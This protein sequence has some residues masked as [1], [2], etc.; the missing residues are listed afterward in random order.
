MGA[1]E[2]TDL[3]AASIYGDV[4]DSQS[5][6]VMR[7][8]QTD[9]A[10][11][12][13]RIVVEMAEKVLE[14][15]PGDLRAMTIRYYAANMLGTVAEQRHDLARAEASYMKSA[16][17]AK[18]YTLFNP[19]DSAGWNSLT[20]SGR[21]LARINLEQG[22]LADAKRM[23]RETVAV[24]HDPRN[25]TGMD[26]GVYW[27]WRTLESVQA[28]EDDLPAA[29]AALGEI[30]RVEAVLAKD[31]NFDPALIQIA[32]LAMRLMEFDLLAAQHDYA[33]LHARAVEVRDELAKLVVNDVRNQEFRDDLT[34]ANRTWIIESGLRLGSHE[35]AVTVARDAVEHP[36]PGRLDQPDVD[37]NQ[38]RTRV[39]LGQA[40][41]DNGQRAEG[42][43][44]LETALKYFRA[45][46]AKGA[47][48]TS[49]RQNYARAL[50]QLARAPGSDEAGQARRR[51][52]LDAAAGVLG[53]LT[54]EAQTL[55]TS[56]ELLQ[57]V[58]AA[59]AQAGP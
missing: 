19:A 12:L 24:E 1:L 32:G 26:A 37:A 14:Q 39:R 21:D 35:E 4:T 18:N 34:R 22:R 38:A 33:T 59:R 54:V 52:L 20:T 16:E 31:R 29:R 7:L 45:E 5:R 43:A 10:E 40:L 15:R 25:K 56:R 50:L 49:F 11:R 28:E 36:I 44:E 47:G 48:G 3:T 17:A 23:L 57:Q 58:I 2:L 42:Q 55:R 8:G 51:T 27:A 41:L 46:E 30:H 13:A 6:M 9:E 53:G